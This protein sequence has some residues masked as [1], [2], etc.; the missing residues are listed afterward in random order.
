MAMRKTH[1]PQSDTTL[2]R[3]A[4]ITRAIERATA[5]LRLVG[6]TSFTSITL[7][8]VEFKTLD[9]E[10]GFGGEQSGLIMLNTC[11]GPFVVKRAD[12]ERLSDQDAAFVGMP[13]AG[14]GG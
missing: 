2:A 1:S 13:P 14:W 10:R 5:E 9:A 7:D 8:P 4:P 11:N 6:I 12:S 3:K